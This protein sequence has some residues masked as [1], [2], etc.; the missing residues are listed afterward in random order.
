M[1]AG[2]TNKIFYSVSLIYLYKLLRKHDMKNKIEKKHSNFLSGLGPRQ[3][4]RDG[5]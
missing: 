3:T 2:H 5:L 4:A 1:H